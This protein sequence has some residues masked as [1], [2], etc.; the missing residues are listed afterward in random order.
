VTK[1]VPTNK[2]KSA[3]PEVGSTRSQRA[4]CRANKEQDLVLNDF[5]NED[6]EEDD[7]E[8]DDP[9]IQSEEE[10]AEKEVILSVKDQKKL[11]LDKKK[12]ALELETYAAKL[13]MR[14]NVPQKPAPISQIKKKTSQQSNK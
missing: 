7:E 10:S 4:S 8:E 5:E 13:A 6:S 14:N 3:A 9:E 12:A 2:T 1:K 11:L